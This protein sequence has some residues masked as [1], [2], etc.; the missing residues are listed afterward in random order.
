[1]PLGQRAGPVR[2]SS[3]SAAVIAMLAIAAMT[4][5]IRTAR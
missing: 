5:A 3:A 4:A 2:C 1:M